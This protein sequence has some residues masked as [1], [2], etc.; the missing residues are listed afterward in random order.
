[1][2][3]MKGALAGAASALGVWLLSLQ[4][5]PAGAGQPPLPPVRPTIQFTDATVPA[6][7]DFRH[8]N[9]AAGDHYYPEQIGNGAAFFDY[10]GDGW[11]DVFV[12]QGAPMPGFRGEPPAG[13]RLFRNMRDGR[14]SDV[15]DAA[16]LHDVRFGFGVAAADYDNDGDTDLYVTNLEG[17]ALYRNDGGGHFTDVTSRARVGVPA[18]ST[19]AAF[20][21]YDG[22][23]RLDLFVARYM[24]WTLD[25]DVRCVDG[26]GMRLG[27]AFISK[28]ART[29]APKPGRVLSY[30]GPPVY[31]GTG[32][33]L[34]HND[35]DG[36]FTDVSD[37]S[38]IGRFIGHGFGVAVSDYNEDGRPDIFVANDMMPNFLF[39]NSGDGAFREQAMA[40]GVAVPLNGT[41]NAGMGVDAA[42]YDNDGHVDL[43]ITNYQGES[44]SLYRNRGDG[45]FT[46]E[47]IRSGITIYTRPFLKWGCR[48]ADLNLDGRLDLLVVNG[49]VDDNIEQHMA[50]APSGAPR[51]TMGYRQR[52]QVFMNDA[53]NHF[54]DVSARAGAY[55]AEGH[56]GRGL[57]MADY[58]NDGDWDALVLNTGERAVLLRNDTVQS[59]RW[60]RLA[61]RGR[62]C[63]RDA[64]GARVQIRTGTTTQTQFVK[65]G[66]S[67][68]S[69]H[70]R[71]LL[72]ALP[73]TEPATAEIRWPCGAVQTVDVAP[74]TSATI[75][76]Q[77][78]LL[79]GDKKPRAFARRVNRQ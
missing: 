15:T 22:D 39:V 14:F 13:N 66:G 42:D 23:G 35:G 25:T 67:Y 24:D 28:E 69:D 65:S 32:N 43:F 78:C 53:A 1:L 76:E 56:L 38:G 20:V 45:T 36:R 74:G 3:I 2:F 6:G 51:A 68:L 7:F 79:L 77:H 12:V 33:R 26:E 16:G 64:I 57:A 52:A 8:V 48:F 17:G 61:L 10:D 19:S 30:C 37:R 70:D 58:D 34:F 31:A 47:G 59:A 73:G 41:P 54:S 29:A 46:D 50:L 71:R 21:D 27:A 11:L 5:P 4:Q 40:A 72:V 60:A 44:S 75:E 49:H 55:F 18:L 62:G 9:G 63:N